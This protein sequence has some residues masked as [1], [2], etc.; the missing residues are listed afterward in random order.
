MTPLY[1]RLPKI[2]DE[3]YAELLPDDSQMPKKL[4]RE[5]LRYYS[6]ALLWGRLI[7]IKARRNHVKLTQTERE[8]Q[9]RIQAQDWNMPQPLY[10]FLRGIGHV[11]DPRGQT[12]WLSDL[13]LPTTA[14][15]G[16]AG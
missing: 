1:A 2:S 6:T 8:F 16:K 13:N 7:D 15:G 10:L 3:V 14:A 5:W 4:T 12:I 11:R 9:E